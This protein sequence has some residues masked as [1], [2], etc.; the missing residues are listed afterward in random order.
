MQKEFNFI[1]EKLVE[2]DDDFVGHVAYSIYKK[3]KLEYINNKKSEGTPITQKILKPFNDFS[4]TSSQIDTYRIKAE[5]LLQAFLESSVGEAVS[6]IQDDTIRNQ[7]ELLRGIVNPPK[8]VF[9]WRVLSG[10]VSGF[11][12]ALIIALIALIIEFKG[13][14][15]NINVT[16]ENQ[17]KEEKITSIGSDRTVLKKS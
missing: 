15:I 3:S 6:E 17:Q 11:I 13:T 12:F 9:W 4:N 5:V 8:H 7:T 10:V 14:S 2:D 1:Y 16:P